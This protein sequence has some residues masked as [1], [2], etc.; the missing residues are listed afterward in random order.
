MKKFLSLLLA[1]SM[2]LALAACGGGNTP[3]NNGG[4]NN[5]GNGQQ[6]EQQPSGG[7][8]DAADASETHPNRLIYGVTTQMSGELGTYSWFNNNATDF[9]IDR[10]VHGGTSNGYITVAANQMG[11]WV[12]NPT[13]VDGE[14]E[15]VKN[16]DGTHTVTT[17]IQEDLLWNNGEPITA[18]DYVA[19]SLVSL[20]P[21]AVEAGSWNYSDSLVGAVEYQSGI[22]VLDENGDPV[23]VKYEDG[24]MVLDDNGE[25]IPDPEGQPLVEYPG[26]ISSLHLIDDYTFSF[27]VT[28]D[29]ADYYY[30]TSLVG[31][32]PLYL[33]KFSED[34]VVKDDG[35]GAYLEGTLTADDIIRV[36]DDF[37]H[38]VTCG[39]YILAS[40]DLSSYSATLE[41]N[42]Y[43][44]GNFEGVK[45]SIEQ[46]V[47]TYVTDT[48]QFDSLRTGVI[49]ALNELGDSTGINEGLNLVEE[50]GYNYATFDR[51]GYGYLGFVCDGG[52]TQFAEVRHAIAYL[53]DRNE[54]CNTFTGG[55][56]MVVNGPYGTGMWQ[57]A[58]S[59]EFLATELNSYSYSP[60]AAVA[61]LEAGGWTLNEDGTPYSGSGIRWKEVTAE[62]AGDYQYNVT[63]ADGRILMPL[64]IEW[65]C[66]ENNSVSDLLATMLMNGP[67]TAE[68]GIKINQTVMTFPQ[69]QEQTGRSSYDPY[70]CGM[71]NM[72]TGFTSTYDQ[73]YYYGATPDNPYDAYDHNKLHD[74]ELYDLAYGMTMATAPEDRDGYLQ[75]FQGFIARWNELLPDI[76]LYSNTYHAFFR[77]WL[78]D[79]EPD[80][81]WGFEYAIIYASIENAVPLN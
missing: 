48:T 19:A 4:G 37:D 9:L 1:L 69:L 60:E 78:K 3:A 16:E 64:E 57:Y 12:T 7:G 72:A 20:S 63:L 31:S 56:G 34:L 39:P 52:P 68:A 6:D 41:I 2:L 36:R 62:E 32:E 46:I 30:I 17:K 24:K 51:N 81:Q 50:G 47:I 67:Q 22:Q 11:E 59:E 70:T 40:A 44:K 14:I 10:M 58:D 73:Y 35:D 38:P 55:Y 77:D 28:A 25:P 33:K 42:P 65:Y 54:F 15:I 13:V 49:D 76:P 8:D 23:L 80:S 66:S 45:P 18:A 21:Q 74:Q 79:Y 53:L 71:F 27:D 61:E 75:K 29:Y 43:Y 26:K 5:Q